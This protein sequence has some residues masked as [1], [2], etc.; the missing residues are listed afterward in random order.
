VSAPSS[1]GAGL[2]A[3]APSPP[4]AS[5]TIRFT[6]DYVSLSIEGQGIGAYAGIGAVLAARPQS[7]SQTDRALLKIMAE[8]TKTPLSNYSSRWRGPLPQALV[9][10][11][12][13]TL[14]EGTAGAQGMVKVQLTGAQAFTFE[15]VGSEIEDGCCPFNPYNAY[16]DTLGVDVMYPWEKSPGREHSRTFS[17]ADLPP[18]YIDEHLVTNQKFEHFMRSAAYQPRDELNFLR[19]WVKHHLT[20]RPAQ[21]TEQQPVRWVSLEDAREYCAWRGARLPQEVEWQLAAQGADQESRRPGRLYPWGNDAPDG[22]G[23]RVPKPRTDLS[24]PFAPDDVGSHPEGESPYGVHDMVG[25]LWQWT[26]EFLDERTRAATLRGGSAYQPASTDQFGDNW[27]FPGGAP[28]TVD[29]S[30]TPTF[31]PFGNGV[32]WGSGKYPRNYQLSSHAKLL[33]MAPS[34]D[35]S[36]GIGFRCAADVNHTAAAL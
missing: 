27:Y 26:S 15:V 35:R 10:S 36:G 4:A 12:N 31:V 14:D 11:P 30:R 25:S 34:L 29:A 2:G 28:Y 17:T 32:P 20:K 7:L 23:K 13:A 24:Q 22:S 3:A 5:P 6:C 19:H 33:L 21:G 18:F 8:H 9:P 16:Y 1:S